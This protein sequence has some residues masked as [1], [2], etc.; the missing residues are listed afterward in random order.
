[1]RCDFQAGNKVVFIELEVSGKQTGR[2]RLTKVE[3]RRQEAAS[4]PLSTLGGNVG[5]TKNSYRERVL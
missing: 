4:T 5:A 3:K 1:M 2:Y